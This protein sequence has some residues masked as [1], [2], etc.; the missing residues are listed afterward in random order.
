MISD[1]IYVNNVGLLKAKQVRIL[2]LEVFVSCIVS[3]LEYIHK[4]GIIHRD[5]KPENL[6]LD[7]TGLVR[8]TDFGIA[9]VI[10]PDNY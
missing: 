2:I 9:W 3:A 4:K 1:I 7:T 6:V 5:L 10:K 8:L